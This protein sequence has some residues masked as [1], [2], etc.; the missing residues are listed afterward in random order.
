MTTTPCGVLQPTS[1]FTHDPPPRNQHQSRNL[2]QLPPKSAS[3]Q[4]PPVVASCQQKQLQTKVVT[5]PRTPL[6]PAAAALV[7][8]I[9]TPLPMF[10]QQQQ[11]QQHSGQTSAVQQSHGFYA[12][13]TQH[14]PTIPASPS[15]MSTSPTPSGEVEALKFNCTKDTLSALWG[16]RLV[17]RN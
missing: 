12:S 17:G 11:Q 9:R 14:S 8:A 7:A 3:C 4:L 10:P 16:A 5:L 15:S 6:P 2:V 1:Q 13:A